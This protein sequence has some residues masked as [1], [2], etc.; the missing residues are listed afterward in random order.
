MVKHRQIARRIKTEIRAE[1]CSEIAVEAINWNLSLSINGKLKQKTIV[2]S[3]VG[4]SADKLYPSHER[5][6]E[7]V[8]QTGKSGGYGTRG[9]MKGVQS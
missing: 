2:Q 7:R 6:Q 3:L 5:N 8:F 1:D 4:K 9:T